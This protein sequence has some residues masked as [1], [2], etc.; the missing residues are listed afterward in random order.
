MKEILPTSFVCTVKERCR[1]CYTCVRECP[2][3]AIRIINGQADVIAERCIGCGN[4]VR[5]CS[6]KAKKVLDSKPGVYELLKSDYKTAAILAPSFPAEFTEISWARLVGMIRKLGFDYVN[7]VG[8]GADLVA[9]K[10]RKLLEQSD[11]NCRYIATSCPAIIAYVERY[12]PD[13]VKNLTP[14]VSPM[15]AAAKMLHRLYGDGLKIVFIGPC[16]AKKGEIASVNITSEVNESLTFVELRDMFNAQSISPENSEDS[17]FDEPSAGVGAIFP[18][19]R[20]LFQSAGIEEDLVSGQIVAVEGSSFVDA[21]EEFESGDM[22]VR[23]LEVLACSGCIM[24]PG[25]SNAKPLFSRRSCV[26][27]YV[28]E[29]MK[30]LDIAKWK[31]NIKRFENLDLSR[32]FAAFDQRIKVTGNGIEQI[33]RQMGKTV[34]A[35]ELNCGACG[36][37]TCRQHAMAIWKGQAESEMCLPYVIEQL[38]KNIDDLANSNNQLANMQEALMQSEKLASMGQ[39]AAGVAHEINNPLGV[40]L[41]YAHLLL[42]K[43]HNNADLNGDLRLISEQADRCKKIVGGL[44]NFARK[45][46]AILQP[47]DIYEVIEKSIQAV[48]NEKCVEIIIENT[49]QDRIAE[50]DSD[51]MSQVFSNLVANAIAAT[52]KTGLITITMGGDNKNLN[53]KVIDSGVGIAKENIS[54]I[55]DPFFTTKQIGVGTGLGLAV[56]YGI[57]KMHRGDIEV[58]SNA[59]PAKGP[60]GTTFTVILRRKQ[61]DGF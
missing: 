42:E 38:H 48:P 19:G 57:V 43:Y 45:N 29:K 22:K 15:V 56:A 33:L 20:G 27:G 2:A 35:D 32:K 58:E 30:N 61:L 14:I 28:Q 51:Q 41:M 52:D 23:L 39:L 53:I 21:F 59:D 55:F 26:S 40:V 9:D 46:K 36:Y 4:C 16:I 44:L 18:I 7:E 6:Q 37:S 11:P 60:T 25:I 31:G 13:L 24:G 3:K 49:L 50:L 5:V 8:F 54:R 12:H 17:V 47:T 10:Y 1:I 34:P